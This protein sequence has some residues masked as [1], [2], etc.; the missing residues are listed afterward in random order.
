MTVTFSEKD[1]RR[2]ASQFFFFASKYFCVLAILYLLSGIVDEDLF[3]SHN[4][5]LLRSGPTPWRDQMTPKD[6]LYDKA[7]REGW[8]EPVWSSNTC[9]MVNRKTYKLKDFEKNK[10]S[11]RRTLTQPVLTLI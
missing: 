11:N 6:W 2:I 1:Q 3:Q 4:H 9:V 7:R 10:V 5:L 8:D